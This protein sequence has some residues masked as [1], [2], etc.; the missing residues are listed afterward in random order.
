MKKTLR[1]LSHIFGFERLSKYENDY[2]H[3]AN[4][5]SS[6]YMG[7]IV[8]ILELWML[9]RQ[10]YSKILPKLQDGGDFLELLIK[11]TSKYWLF[12]L[13]GLGLM[14]FCLF[15]RRD[16]KLSKGK[17]I[18]LM[19]VGCLC[20]LYTP[21]LSLETFTK[22]GPTRNYEI[23]PLMANLMNAMLISIYVLLFVIGAA[24]VAYSLVKYLKN[25]NIVVLEHVVITS[26]TLICLAFGV[27][28]SYS[29]FWGGKEIICFLT[30]VIYVGCLL[31]YRPY[32]TVLILGASFLGFYRILLTF[33]GGGTFADQEIMISGV[34]QRIISGD[35]V[36]YL[37][38]FISLTTICFAIY[39]GRLTEAKKSK[40][41][42]K[43]AKEDLLTGMYNY[44]YFTELAADYIHGLN[45][46]FDENVLLF[47]DV[48]NFKAFN[49]QRGFEEGDKFLITIGK[50]VSD[51]FKDSLCA[52][53]A[54]DHFVVLAKTEGLM[55]KL[56]RLNG[57]VSD[58]DDEILLGINCGAYHLNGNNEDPRMA[59]DRARYASHLIKNRFQTVYAE[60]DK[61]M[62]E[63]Y[64]KRLHVINNIDNAVNNG[65]IVP[66]YQP[67]VWSDTEKLCGCE[68]L[69]RWKD[70]VY[71]QLFPNEF[72]PVLEEY[73]LIH[74]LDRCIFE[75]VCRDLR[76]SL[77]AGK[78]VV[79]VS[80]N[81][82]RLDFELMDAVS[83]L[84][85]LV[86]KYDVPK[87]LIHVE[88]TESALTDNFTKLNEAI[89]RIKE[90]GYAL[91][92]DDF[93]S[94]YSSLNV[95][96]DYQ[97]D[98]IKIDMRFL[99]NFENS[100]KSRTLID[101]IIK[102]ANRINML[103]L[104]EGVETKIQAEFLNKVGCNRLQGYLFG[105]PIP[106]E[107]LYDRIG[108]GELVV[109]DKIL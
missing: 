86:K 106:I 51:I 79:P 66:F 71:G 77:D 48:H 103:T 35:A 76:N 42:E 80:L 62:S 85:T 20:M 67:V 56:D 108:K 72:I 38:F 39:H 12:L 101:C 15:Y 37:T 68:A 60:Y 52:R 105:K 29:D 28:V 104:T 40:A 88:V 92:L 73:R 83:E 102:M 34:M 17:F 26:F 69:A 109:S 81:F 96:K 54:D 14:L 27:F 44:G 99:S 23:T 49:D 57:M 43:T 87:E 65:W 74:K 70:P 30:M 19:I 47:L 78:P 22:P 33:E 90:L 89:N 25:K 36:N 94:G 5:R 61:T 53:Q 13:I 95:L 1:F 31:I 18:T 58:Y 59:I 84:E 46:N 24:I 91:W 16:R 63:A 100:D 41:L 4:I 45:G 107:K 6:S 75:S 8:V 3:D 9:I 7:F 64:H 50:Y 21:V 97:F 32:V 93:G 98:V 2:L 11:Y 10:S 82:S 55:E